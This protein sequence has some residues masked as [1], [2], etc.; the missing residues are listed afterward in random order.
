M[1]RWQ[2][3]LTHDGLW[4]PTIDCRPPSPIANAVVVNAHRFEDSDSVDSDRITH[5]TV[6]YSTSTF[7]FSTDLLLPIAPP[8]LP[9]YPNG[10]IVVLRR[11]RLGR[12]G[13][14]FFGGWATH[15]RIDP[16]YWAFLPRSVTSTAT[17]TT[18]CPNDISNYFDI[19]ESFWIRKRWKH[20][21]SS[22]DRIDQ[23]RRSG[24][25]MM[26]YDCLE[27]NI[28]LLLASSSEQGYSAFVFAIT[29]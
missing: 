21:V 3:M 9:L 5:R 4:I 7:F 8:P 14:L 2:S 29:F 26:P 24:I 16:R 20:F 19:Q 27:E 12:S 22:Y 6:W 18:S 1:G 13:T 25:P 17:T 11:R 28:W 23:L 15:H 10:S